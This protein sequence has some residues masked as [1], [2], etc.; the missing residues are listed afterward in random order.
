MPDLDLYYRNCVIGGHGAFIVV[1]NS[2]KDYAAAV[3]R[4]LILEIAG[5][6]LGPATAATGTVIRAEARQV[7]PC[8]AG[9]MRMRDWED[10]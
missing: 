1:A 9:E 5:R 7:P 10:Y 8:N 2:F 6:T 3:L 4:K